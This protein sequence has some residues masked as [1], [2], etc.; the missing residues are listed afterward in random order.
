MDQPL[1]QRRLQALRHLDADLQRLHFGH[2]LL[3]GHQVVQR[4][5]VHQLHGDVEKAVV[6]P[7]GVDLH[8]VRVIDGGGD[9]GLALEFREVFRIRGKLLR[10]PP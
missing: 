10:A 5:F 4:T 2:A 1:L 9:P 3:Q 6:G 8:H 7:E